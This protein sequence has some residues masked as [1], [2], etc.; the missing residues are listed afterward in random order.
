MRPDTS[1]TG[2]IIEM[3]GKPL[4]V[5]RGRGHD[6][7]QFRPVRQQLLQIPQQ[8]INIE[9]ALVRF[10][11]DDGVVCA[12]RWIA[13]GFRQQDAVCHQ[14]DISPRAYIVGKADLVA[15]CFAQGTVK[16]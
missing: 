10:I 13:L 2:R 11:D 8:K 4:R 6:K 15:H 1:T 5:D 7:L 12:Q 14:L 16:L 9:T 3:L